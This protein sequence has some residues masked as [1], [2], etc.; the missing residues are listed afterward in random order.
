MMTDETRKPESD[1]NRGNRILMVQTNVPRHSR[2]IPS[3]LTTATHQQISLNELARYIVGYLKQNGIVITQR[4]QPINGIEPTTDETNSRSVSESPTHGRYFSRIGLDHFVYFDEGQGSIWRDLF[5][6]ES[7]LF[8]PSS[9][10]SVSR[11]M[12]IFRVDDET[13]LNKVTESLMGRGFEKIDASR[14]ALEKGFKTGDTSPL[15]KIRN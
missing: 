1:D 14:D 8:G 3:A 12:A 4:T 13:S 10:W 11:T 2:T 6:E 15:I 5:I 7:G 9:A